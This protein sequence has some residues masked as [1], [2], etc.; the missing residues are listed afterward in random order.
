VCV[1]V[2]LDIP[3]MYKAYSHEIYMNWTERDAMHT[4]TH[5]H[6]H[7]HTH[8]RAYQCRVVHSAIF[9]DTDNFEEAEEHVQREERGSEHV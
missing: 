7:K 4:N 2:D 3:Y 9:A 6:T 5:K 8:T 1:C